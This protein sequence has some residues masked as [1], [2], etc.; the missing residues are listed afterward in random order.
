MTAVTVRRRPRRPSIPS[1]KDDVRKFVRLIMIQ[2]R[3]EDI[4]VQVEPAGSAAR[5]RKCKRASAI[6]C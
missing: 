5:S 3:I 1:R 6:P 4:Q 2:K